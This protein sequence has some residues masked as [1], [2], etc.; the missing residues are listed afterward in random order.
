MDL[1]S[2]LECI[3]LLFVLFLIYQ[4]YQYHLI[5]LLISRV[6]WSNTE[7]SYDH[8]NSLGFEVLSVEECLH[9][10]ADK[11][12]VIAILKQYELCMQSNFFNNAL[13][14]SKNMRK[15][16]N[17]EYNIY[18]LACYLECIDCRLELNGQK[19]LISTKKEDNKQY[20]NLTEHGYSFYRFFHII[21]SYCEKNDKIMKYARYSNRST[22]IKK[23][24]KNGYDVY[25]KM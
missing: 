5:K 15:L 9:Y 20:Y 22:S 4:A 14:N 6:Q 11:K 18:H 17:Q 10:E 8:I 12:L 13:S 24:L 23:I 21:S 16:N 2:T 19:L 1:Y 25:Y 3:L 7:L